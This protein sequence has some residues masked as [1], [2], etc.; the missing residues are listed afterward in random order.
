MWTVVFLGIASLLWLMQLALGPQGMAAE[1]WLRGLDHVALAFAVLA[2]AQLLLT[3]LLPLIRRSGADGQSARADLLR[4]LLAAVVYIGVFFLY[5][6]FGLGFDITALLATSAALSL[7]VG[8]ALQATL[9][10]L[11]AGISIELERVVRVGDYVRRGALA[12]RVV[13]LGWRSIHMRSEA[14]SMLVVPNSSITSDLLEVIPDGE[15][16]RHEI[17]FV[18]SEEHP[19]GLVMQAA[20]RV[21]RSQIP[22][23]CE[24]K[25]ADVILREI[26]PDSGVFRYAAR[27]YVSAVSQRHT[28]GSNIMERMWYELA[29]LDE[30]SVA[31]EKSIDELLSRSTSWGPVLRRALSSEAPELETQLLKSAQVRRYARH[32]RFRERGVSLI[33]E[34]GVTEPRAPTDAAVE[35]D[36][37]LA[38]VTRSVGDDTFHS[39]LDYESVH[40]LEALGVNYVGPMAGKLCRRIA[41]ATDDP[42]IAYRAFAAFIPAG[43]SR[44]GFLMQAPHE[45]LRLMRA[46]TWLGLESPPAGY[47]VL[48][49]YRAHENSTLLSW[50]VEDFRVALEAC[51]RD[52]PSA[53]AALLRRKM[54]ARDAG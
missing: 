5:V 15:P 8:L 44:D 46:G 52:A 36:E 21:L 25:S 42:W 27:F 13:S 40:S 22:G 14:G 29:R 34:G 49:L 2:A 18:V 19:P 43:S 38:R 4:T 7:V 50:H 39:R 35:L 12:G 32:E 33:L 23:L 51:P 53:L 54:S 9:G 3:L 20:T 26:Q 47:D 1:G 28:V 16:Y 10:N 31:H 48:R 41:E 17:E 11:F 30:R 6:H 24:A 37:V 45:S